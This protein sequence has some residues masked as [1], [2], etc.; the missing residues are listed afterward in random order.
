MLNNINNYVK[1]LKIVD[2]HFRSYKQLILKLI[3]MVGFN[4][5]KTY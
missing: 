5:A 3:L 4:N 1:S 2:W